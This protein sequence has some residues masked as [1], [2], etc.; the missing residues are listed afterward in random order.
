MGEASMNEI[1]CIFCNI[2]SKRVVIE[3]NGYTSKKC[4]QCGLVYLSPRPSFDDII[5]LYGH[6]NAYISADSHISGGYLKK[7]YARHNLGIIRSF[8]RSGELLDIGA[9]AGY[10]L[11]EARNLG[12]N[13]HGLEFNPIQADHIRD[14]LKIPCEESPIAATLFN[15]KKFD[16]VYHC[17]VISHFYNPIEDFKKINEKMKVGGF[18]VFETGNLGEVDQRYYKYF[19]RFQLPDH[20]FFFSAENLMDLCA[21]TGFEFVKIYRY[22][23][24]PQLISLR[25]LSWVRELKTKVLSFPADKEKGSIDQSDTV[26]LQ[27]SIDSN[28]GSKQGF[29]KGLLKK[30][31][32]Y[33]FSYALRYKIG[34]IAPK[35]RRPQTVI[36]VARK[37]G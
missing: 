7:L 33:F 9:G 5:D 24:L 15:G 8:I 20:L 35:K 36:L 1:E 12:F 32:Q 21:E 22:S 28:K 25:V 37:R 34:R 14:K 10:F 2:E 11:Y 3:E 29:I 31:H 30:G 4:P 18:L 19:L 23:I 26:A 17:D 6:D 16:V 13:P 27:P